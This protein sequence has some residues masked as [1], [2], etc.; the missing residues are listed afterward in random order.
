[1]SA[2]PE[3]SRRFLRERLGG[4]PR[5]E[6]LVADAAERAALSARFGLVALDRLEADV[7]LEAVP[8]G[9]ACRGRLKAAVVQACVVSGEPVA[10]LVDVPFDLLFAR[11]E[12]LPAEL[13]LDAEALDRLPLENGWADIGEAVAQ[14]LALALDPYPR[15]PDGSLVAARARLMPEEEAEALLAST[16][17]PSP[18]GRLKAR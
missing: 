7:R 5:V 12:A 8:D 9:I 18:F 3:F 16:P 13:E 14:T 11:E 4:A 17:R 1:V 15:A 10:A 6:Q 2:A